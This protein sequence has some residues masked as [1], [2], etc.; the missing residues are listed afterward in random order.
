MLEDAF[1][2]LSATLQ[3]TPGQSERVESIVESFLAELDQVTPCDAKEIDEWL[4][5]R[6]WREPELADPIA[7]EAEL[8]PTRMF[9]C[10][11]RLR[12]TD[13]EAAAAL[14]Q[15]FMTA[16]PE[17]ERAA[18]AAEDYFAN[19]DYCERPAA[20]P[21]APPYEGP[22]PHTMRTFGVDPDEYD[23]P[24]SW[25]ADGVDDTVLVVCVE[26]P[27]RGSHQQSCPYE[28]G[29]DQVLAPNQT[30]VQ[31]DFYASKFTVRAYEF[32]TGELVEDYTEEIGEPCPDELLYDSYFL[33]SVPSEHNSDYSDAQLR[34][35]FDRLMD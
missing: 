28:P 2:Q 7:P 35:V 12:G 8:L 11:Q 30:F 31:V 25:R 27:D 9:D 18:E 15:E 26:G 17:H 16:Y 32:R 14:Y 6:T 23:F 4:L 24:D 10:A 3:D 29:A 34:S 21:G 20:Y 13:S 5:A 33:D 19:A 1:T 22:G